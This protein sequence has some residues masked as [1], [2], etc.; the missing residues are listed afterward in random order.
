M[1]GL[2][3][4]KAIDEGSG[5]AIGG[6]AHWKAHMLKISD[7]THSIVDFARSPIVENR[8]KCIYQTNAAKA[9][10]RQGAKPL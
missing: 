1:E 10:D 2:A 7:S 6:K 8:L 9:F 4:I 3:C 5:T